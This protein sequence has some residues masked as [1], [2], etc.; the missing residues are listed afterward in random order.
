MTGRV[1]DMILDPSTTRPASRTIIA[2]GGYY[3]MQ[4]F[5]QALYAHV[6]L[7]SRVRSR[8]RSRPPPA[9]TTSS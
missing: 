1:R 7:G 5:D 3:G 6:S 9:R 8:T 2:E 4:T